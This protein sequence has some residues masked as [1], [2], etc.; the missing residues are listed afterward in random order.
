MHMLRYTK[1]EDWSLT[2]TNNVQCPNLFTLCK[3]VVWL[4]MLWLATVHESR[5]QRSLMILIIYCPLTCSAWM[6]HGSNLVSSHKGWFV[7][8]WNGMMQMFM[9]CLLIVSNRR[10]SNARRQQT[11]R[12]NFHCLRSS[13]H[14]HNSENNGFTR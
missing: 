12:V 5:I 9:L 4:Y 6:T 8:T 7:E 13:E 10:L 3:K 14:A 2:I 11:Y 1:W